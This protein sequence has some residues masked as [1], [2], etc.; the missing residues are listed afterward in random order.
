MIQA[1]AS[2]PRRIATPR[3]PTSHALRDAI[4]KLGELLLELGGDIDAIRSSWYRIA[5]LDPAHAGKR[6]AVM[7]SCW[8]GI[9]IG[10]GK[11][12]WIS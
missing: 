4:R 7:D 6:L 1:P 9:G 8:N 11:G 12:M 3:Q 5:E 10:S 2:S